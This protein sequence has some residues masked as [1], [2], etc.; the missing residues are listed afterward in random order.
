MKIDDDYDFHQFDDL[1]IDPEWVRDLLSTVEIPEKSV[2]T[3]SPKRMKELYFVYN[4]IKDTITGENVHYILTAN[5]KPTMSAT[6]RI[7]GKNLTVLDT[8]RFLQMLRLASVS[9][10]LPRTDK[11]VECNLTFHNMSISHE[12]KE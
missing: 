11:Q 7:I 4:H 8:D 10:L 2:I 5:G 9:E 3:I 1:E 12:I 6:I